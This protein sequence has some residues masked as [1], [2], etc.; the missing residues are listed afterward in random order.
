M[1]ALQGK[2][3]YVL[4]RANRSHKPVFE[5]GER[6]RRVL[7]AGDGLYVITTNRSPREQSMSNDSLIRLSP[8]G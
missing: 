6:Y 2:G 5:T 1:A 4:D 7:S 8:V 3:L